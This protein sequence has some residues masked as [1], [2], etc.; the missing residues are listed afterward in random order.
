[1]K[2]KEIK[3][4]KFLY[5]SGI[6][7][8]T[9]LAWP[10]I[11]ACSSNAAN[12]K[13]QN[14][15]NA[16]LND[17]S[18]AFE[19]DLEFELTAVEKDIS[20]FSGSLTSVWM[21]ESKLIKGDQSTL[22]HIK[23]SYLG[24]TINVSKGQKVRIRFINKLNEESIVH[25]HGLH[26]PEQ[27][28]GHP[29]DVIAPGETYIYE[30]EI[31]NNAGT[32]WYHP[33]PHK[34]TGQQVYNGLAGMFIVTDP[35]EQALNLPS[36][37]YDFPIVIQDRTID[38]DNQL[39]YF[40]S[41]H[42]RRNDGFLG[43][44]IFINGTPS[45][46]ISAEQG[47][48]RLRLLNGSNSRYYKL[49]WAD[50]TPLTIIGTDGNLLSKPKNVPYIMMSSGER[51]DLWLDLGKHAVGTEM[52][53]KSLSFSS[54][55]DEEEGEGMMGGMGHGGGGNQTSIP[56]GSEYPIVK[57]IINKP[58]GNKYKLPESLVN[59]NKLDANNAVNITNPRTFKFAGSMMKWTI[60]GRTFETYGITDYE[61][62]KLNSTEVWEFINSGGGMMGGG[63]GMMGNNNIAHPIHIHQ[64]QFNI[65]ERNSENMNAGLWD[66]IKEGFVDEGWKDTFLLMPGMKIKVLIAFK[67]FK[68]NFLYHCHNL[69]HEDMGMMRNYSIN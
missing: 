5:Y 58:G 61:T 2:K 41:G 64:A 42:M 44:Q 33:H 8:A 59:L 65:I 29:K 49:A 68:G 31:M 20:I 56:L 43:D 11:S 35:A 69:E 12:S 39:V 57:I 1:M 67:D 47:A 37:K 7:A 13:Y 30:Y 52:V 53:L 46:T 6:G 55:R 32:Y 23:G 22:A 38:D 10:L 51:I 9:L 17:G 27:Y 34:L 60:N 24:P 16:K 54:N 26:V 15:D 18:T 25:W 14:A 50:G 28:D 3:R 45:Q 40:N 63:H 36:G 66:S 19:P 4:R 48:Y 21:F 62:V